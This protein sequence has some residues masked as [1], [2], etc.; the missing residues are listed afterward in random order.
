MRF[1]LVSKTYAVIFLDTNEAIAFLAILAV[2]GLGSLV[3]GSRRDCCR[4][5]G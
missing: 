1:E 5:R 4:S 3:R 2:T